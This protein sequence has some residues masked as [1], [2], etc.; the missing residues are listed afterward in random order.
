MNSCTEFLEASSVKFQWDRTVFGFKTK[1]LDTYN[2]ALLTR[3]VIFLALFS[4]SWGLPPHPSSETPSRS[5]CYLHGY[6]KVF[7]V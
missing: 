6:C 3:L 7:I 5:S 2:Q 1:Q 4:A